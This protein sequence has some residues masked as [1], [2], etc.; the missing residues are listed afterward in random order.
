MLPALCAAPLGWVLYSPIKVGSN[1]ERKEYQHDVSDIIWQNA[2]S[3]DLSESVLR[4]GF[5]PNPFDWALTGA[6]IEGTGNGDAMTNGITWALH[7][8]FCKDLK[9]KWAGPPPHPQAHT[10]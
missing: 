10:P 6:A 7:P 9:P 8:D 4:W 3:Y 5:P 1:L 2:T